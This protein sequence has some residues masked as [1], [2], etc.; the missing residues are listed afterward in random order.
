M[1]KNDKSSSQ[2][3]T[4]NTPDYDILDM[5]AIYNMTSKTA[6]RFLLGLFSVKGVGYLT[7]YFL[8]MT[9]LT[10]VAFYPI[11]NAPEKAS[12]PPDQS[13]TLQPRGIERSDIYIFVEKSVPKK[14]QKISAPKNTHSYFIKKSK[15]TNNTESCKQK[16]TATDNR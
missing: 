4:K 16:I 14:M 7:G 6:L 10:F 5:L 11:Q 2:Y 8:A 15:S 12:K 13:F 1:N 9:F 3:E